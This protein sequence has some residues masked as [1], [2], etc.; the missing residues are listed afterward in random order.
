MKPR[1][2]IPA[3][4]FAAFLLTW[5]RWEV[6]GL[7]FYLAGRAR[8]CSVEQAIR[9]YNTRVTEA[10]LTRDVQ[11]ASKLLQESG[12]YQQWATP[13]GTFWAPKP[14]R[15]VLFE[16]VGQQLRG[17]YRS[18]DVRV[19]PGD[20]VLDCGAAYGVFTRTAL[21]EGASLVVAIEPSPRNVECL[22]RTFAREIAA[23]TVIVYPKGLWDREDTLKFWV[24]P[25]SVLDTFVPREWIGEQS[26]ATV[27]VSV[28]TL[29]RLVAELTL[30]KVDFIKM[31]IEG[32]EARAL[33]GGRRTVSTYR[34]KLAIAMEHF[35]RDRDE[36]PEVVRSI[37]SGYRVGAARCRPRR[38]DWTIYPE[39]LFFW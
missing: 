11:A 12:E 4:F 6:L 18:P 16:V 3:G 23:G 10:R 22:R 31:D 29:D 37:W 20:V 8:G 28:T 35:A 34:P 26:S 21:L 39:V 27:E 24:H 32:A 17:I 7:G 1:L 33:Q 2:L 13:H 5:F 25:S 30:N 15:G 38:L 36:I 19:A 14:S 9:S